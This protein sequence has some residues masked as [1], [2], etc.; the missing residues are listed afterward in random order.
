MSLNGSTR[1]VIVWF[2]DDLRL[3]DHPA[4]TEAA[5]DGP[6]IALYILEE[7]C[8]RR[9]PGG[10]SRWWLDRSLDALG[11]DLSARG[12]PLVL[13]RGDP[14]LLLP[15]IAIEAQAS[16]VHWHRRYDREGRDIDAGIKSDLRARGIKAESHNGSLLIEPWQVGT[17]TG[18]WFK[19]FTPF[20]KACQP[21]LAD[22]PRPLP[23]PAGLQGA[24]IGL[25]SDRLSDWGLSPTRPDWAAGLRAT[26]T[27][28]EAGARARLDA[29]LAEGLGR[30]AGQRDVPSADATSNLS[31]HLRFGEISPRTVWHAARFRAA[32]PDV[33][34]RNVTKFLAELGWR[35]FSYQLL[36]RFPDLGRRN[37]QQRFDRFPWIDDEAAFRA[38]TRGR[39]GYPIV[40]AGM[41]QLWATGTMHNRV[42]M[43]VASFLVKDLMIDWRQGEAWFWDTLCDADVANNTAS[44]QWVAGSG[45]DAAPYFRVFNPM[46]QGEKFDPDGRYVRTWVPELADVPSQLIHRPFEAVDKGSGLFSRSLR[47][48]PKP[49]VDHQQAR[50]RALAAFERLKSNEAA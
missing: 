42:R 45:A 50:D 24:A 23:I 36:F 8:G 39:T 4:L 44:W 47:S 25:A 3:S 33:G 20:W 11:R 31:P 12:I 49:V 22:L 7:S 29:F 16:A 6:V 37:F 41:R 10:A 26:W 5:A 43:I 1:P 34:D 9:E 32:D 46:L 28:G 13:R 17:K 21:L 15:A 38:W 19:V 2:R 40:D 14:R 27:P 35:E 48:Y 30:Y 18:D